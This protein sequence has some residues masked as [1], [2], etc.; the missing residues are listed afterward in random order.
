MIILAIGDIVGMPGV[1]MLERHLRAL[2]KLKSADMVI[3]NGEN[4]AGFGITSEL[5]RRLFDAGADVITLGNHTWSNR[6]IVHA[7]DDTP[8]L[9][10]PFNFAP[11]T[12][13]SGL[14]VFE[15]SRGARVGVVS[16]IGR[17]MMSFIPD[18]PFYAADRAL[19]ELEGRADLVM[20]DMHAE[21]TSEKLALAHYLDGRVAGVFGTHT[22]VP[23]ADAQILPGGTG[24]ITD[25]GMTGPIR[26]VL[27]VRPEQ[28]VSYFLGNV[29]K[30]YEVAPGPCVLSG[31][32]F[33]IDDQTG[34]C[35]NVQRI[36]IT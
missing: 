29:P 31:A 18:N 36:E 7:I 8:L 11:Q 22:H 13:G 28:S 24:Y 1:E 21:A 9:L 26:S 16:L 27:G 25:L 33:D 3:V 19:K 32:L 17:C 10:R 4:A 34:K 2:R 6:E 15:T 14:C 12:P 5:A 23:T 20:V 30:R 35:Q